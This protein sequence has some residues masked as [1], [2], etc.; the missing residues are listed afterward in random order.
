MKKNLII[1]PNSFKECA[2]STEAA[3]LIS[4]NFN[5]L[6]FSIKSL[7]LSDGGDGF[8]KVCRNTFKTKSFLVNIPA[9]FGEN[10]INV[11]VEYS[12]KDGTLYIESAKVLGLNL[13][14]PAERKPAELNSRGLGVLLEKAESIFPGLKKINIGIGGTGTN[15]FGIGAA[16]EFGLKLTDIN[17]A[18]LKLYPINYINAAA[19]IMPSTR[20]KFIIEAVVDV[21]NRLLGKNGATRTFAKQK[22]ASDEEIEIM[23]SGFENICRLLVKN[24]IITSSDK[25]NGAGGGLAAG[26][27]V[28]M[29]AEIKYSRDFILNDIGAGTILRNGNIVITGEGKFDRQSLMDKA[30]GVIIDYFGNSDSPV[31]VICGIAD[32]EVLT[33]LPGN[34]TVIEMQKY[35]SSAAESIREFKTGIKKACNEIQDIIRNG[36]RL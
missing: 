34:V 17:R 24:N 3:E 32:A 13:I 19:I 9:P 21:D 29:G 30:P 11:P 33:K 35:F 10:S 4:H 27:Q 20:H 16:A 15:D 26:L 18:E 23:E 25:L 1:A 7:P 6:N 2:D 31:F 22:G 28:F 14:P 36:Y 5:K 8:L 12:E